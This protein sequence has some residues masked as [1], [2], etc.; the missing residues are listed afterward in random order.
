MKTKTNKGILFLIIIIIIYLILL[1]INKELVIKSLRFFLD[2][3]IKII[4]AFILMFILMVVAELL[5]KPKQIAKYLGKESGIK[6]W[7]IAIVTGILSTGP[8][9]L[10]YQL[11]QNLKEKGV[12]E[13]FIAIFLYNRAIKIPLL[14]VMIYYFGAG[15]TIILTIMTIIGSIIQGIIIDKTV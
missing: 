5:I 9:Y 14:P 13:K 2:L 6:S 1:F 4:P 15:Y 8:I 11:L 3:I 12:K 10:W 7:I